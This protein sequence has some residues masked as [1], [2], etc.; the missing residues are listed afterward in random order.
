[1]SPDRH[2][3]SQL[4]L[5]YRIGGEN[6]QHS[7]TNL[8]DG[9]VREPFFCNPDIPSTSKVP[10]EMSLPN[11]SKFLTRQSL[12]KELPFFDGNPMDFINQYRNSNGLC[13]YSNEEISLDYRNV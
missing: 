9:I 2:Y 11:I 7:H 1:M 12:P 13:G 8:E 4:V 10:N 6:T 3:M 5:T